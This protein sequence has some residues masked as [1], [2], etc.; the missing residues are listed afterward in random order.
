MDKIGVAGLAGKDVKL[1]AS[2]KELKPI[3]IKIIRAARD[4][5]STKINSSNP[6]LL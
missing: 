6:P 4:N 3:K 5:C 1:F 2:L